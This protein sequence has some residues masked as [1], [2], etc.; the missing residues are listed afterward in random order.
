[1]LGTQKKDLGAGLRTEV[2]F[3][4]FHNCVPAGTFGTGDTAPRTR[5][6]G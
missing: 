3:F 1:M 4:I 6:G 5:S 2:Y